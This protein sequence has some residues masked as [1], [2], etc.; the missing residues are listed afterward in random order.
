MP[1]IDW[2]ASL[3]AAERDAIRTIA[4]VI[5]SAGVP[6]FGFILTWLARIIRKQTRAAADNTAIKSWIDGKMRSISVAQLAQHNEIRSE[7]TDLVNDPR[8]GTGPVPRLHGRRR[9]TAL[10]TDQITRSPRYRPAESLYTGLNEE[11]N[12]E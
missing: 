10:L 3:S 2:V 9:D 12:H 8:T 4:L 6:V 11:P 7:L 1:L 5:G